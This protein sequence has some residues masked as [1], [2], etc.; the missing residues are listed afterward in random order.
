MMLS[1]F[2]PASVFTHICSLSRKKHSEGLPSCVL[3]GHDSEGVQVGISPSREVSQ[4]MHQLMHSMVAASWSATPP[5]SCSELP[6]RAAAVHCATGRC[7][8]EEAGVLAKGWGTR[9][10]IAAKLTEQESCIEHKNRK[11]SVYTK[12]NFS[13]ACLSWSKQLVC[14]QESHAA[15]PRRTATTGA[16]LTRRK[17]QG[18]L[19]AGARLP[20]TLLVAPQQY[21]TL[22][23]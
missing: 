23:P 14:W 11:T 15:V 9:W 22:L 5:I 8:G 3:V 4:P 19:C 6:G 18:S 16:A 2:S 20:H 7:C 21:F 1:L 10:G 17:K 12:W 13:T